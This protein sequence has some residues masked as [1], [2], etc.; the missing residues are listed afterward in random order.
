M[1]HAHKGINA[2]VAKVLDVTWQSCRVHFMRNAPA[3]AG[4]LGRRV[5][6]AFIATSFAQND[7]EVVRAQWRYRPGTWSP[8][9]PESGAMHREG[10]LRKSLGEV[11]IPKAMSTTPQRCILTCAGCCF[12][13]RCQESVAGALQILARL[14]ATS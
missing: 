14:L 1:P 11:C 7:A 9:K 8:G 2:A 13:Q 6:S 5:V 10:L 4:K 3:H 12:L